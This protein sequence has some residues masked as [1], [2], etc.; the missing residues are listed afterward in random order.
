MN[1]LS[2]FVTGDSKKQRE[3]AW[4]LQKDINETISSANE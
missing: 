2:L 1:G 3:D 4:K